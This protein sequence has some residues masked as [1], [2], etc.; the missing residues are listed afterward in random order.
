MA[1]QENTGKLPGDAS[2]E[3]VRRSMTMMLAQTRAG[4]RTAVVMGL[5]LGLIFVP[6]AGWALYLA[7]LA[8]LVAGMLLRQP[9]FQRVVE[10]EG[11]TEAS[12]RRI[13]IVAAATGWVGSLSVP[14]FGRFLPQVDLG[15]LTIMISGWLAVA[16]SIL[17]VQPRVYAAYLAASGALAPSRTVQERHSSSPTVK[18]VIR[19]KL[20]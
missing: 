8:L 5:I 18:N 4:A 17:A 15:I 3:L 2:A 1:G 19:F 13:A 12:L 7:W 11:P 16:V 20:R 10:R 14:V 9:Y 6:A